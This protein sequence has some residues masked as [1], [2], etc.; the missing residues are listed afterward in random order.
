MRRI[1][2]CLGLLTA[3][4]VGL[5]PA[6]ADAAKKKPKPFKQRVYEGT[7]VSTNPAAPSTTEITLSVGQGR[8]RPV[9]GGKRKKGICL[10]SSVFG[11]YL[12]SCTNNGVLLNGSGPSGSVNASYLLK[13]T[14]TGTLTFR[15]DPAPPPPPAA[16]DTIEITNQFNIS[17]QRITG[18]AMTHMVFVNPGGDLICDGSATFDLKRTR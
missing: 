2:A 10:T 7:V 14:G 1:V 15:Q 11:D 6:G 16:P 18:T 5:A 8:C 4:L 17:K 13:R 9:T 3:L 12:T